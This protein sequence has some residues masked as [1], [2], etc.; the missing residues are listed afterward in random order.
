MY[1][2]LS[3]Y[4]LTELS[5]EKFEKHGQIESSFLKTKYAEHEG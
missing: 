4:C 1:S 3:K 5:D 2:A